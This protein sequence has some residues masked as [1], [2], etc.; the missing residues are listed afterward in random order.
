M[1]LLLALLLFASPAGAQLVRLEEPDQNSMALAHDAIRDGTL[2]LIMTDGAQVETAGHW[3]VGERTIQFEVP[4]KHLLSVRLNEVDFQA[5]ET[6]NQ[7]VRSGLYVD[8]RIKQLENMQVRPLDQDELRELYGEL[9]EEGVK[10]QERVYA[11]RDAKACGHFVGQAAALCAMGQALG[12]PS[13][14]AAFDKLVK[15]KRWIKSGKGSPS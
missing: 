12:R 10:A 14:S 5:T 1:K 15:E 13:A 7:E 6:F 11:E 9:H 2:W 8:K 3:K 4:G